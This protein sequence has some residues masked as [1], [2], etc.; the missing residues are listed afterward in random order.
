MWTVPSCFSAEGATV[1]THTGA[2]IQALTTRL[3]LDPRCARQIHEAVFSTGGC[4]GLYI[5]ECCYV[6]LRVAGNIAG[7]FIALPALV[8]FL[9]Q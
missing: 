9:C 3:C 5:R 6:I 2:G 1:P 7:L 4:A 8:P